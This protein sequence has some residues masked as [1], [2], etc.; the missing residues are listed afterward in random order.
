MVSE[1][2][3]CRF[4]PVTQI[5]SEVGLAAPDLHVLTPNHENY[6]A[7]LL[8]PEGDIEADSGGVR[9]SNRSLATQQFTGFLQDA[10]AI[11]ADLVI[12]P[13][14]SVPW[15]VLETFVSAGTV[16]AL[17]A[18]SSGCSDARAFPSTNFWN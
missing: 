17:G 1:K 18:G 10:V 16:P 8:Q 13:E 4:F 12:T 14:Y 3:Q 9:N 2:Q 6:T 5:L 7:L 11:N 15:C